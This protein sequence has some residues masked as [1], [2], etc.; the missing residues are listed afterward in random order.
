MSFIAGLTDPEKRSVC[1]L[2]TLTHWE[3]IVLNHF[4]EKAVSAMDQCFKL[5]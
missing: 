5:L 3:L 4:E 2:P 1:I